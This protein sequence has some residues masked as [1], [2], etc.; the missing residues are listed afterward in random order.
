[1]NKNNIIIRLEKKRRIPRS[2]KPCKRIILECVP[3][4]LS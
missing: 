3:S 1:M 4:G 2:R